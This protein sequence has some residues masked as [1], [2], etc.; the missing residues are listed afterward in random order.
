MGDIDGMYYLDTD[1]WISKDSTYTN[2]QYVFEHRFIIPKDVVSQDEMMW[3]INA[4]CNEN[5]LLDSQAEIY[6]QSYSDCPAGI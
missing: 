3:R 4:D 5:N 1:E 2:S 6:V